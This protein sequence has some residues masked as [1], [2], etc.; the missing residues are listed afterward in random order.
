MIID[1]FQIDAHLSLHCRQPPLLRQEEL[2]LSLPSTY[3]IWSSSDL[4]VFFDRIQ[5]EP[6]QRRDVRLS[7]A[8][9]TPYRPA[10]SQLLIEDVQLA[11]LGSQYR[12]WL[13][14]EQYRNRCRFGVE[15]ADQIEA[16][17][18]LCSLQ[19]DDLAH[20]LEIPIQDQQ[21]ADFLLRAYS[22]KDKCSDS[23][24]RQAAL[25]RFHRRMLTARVLYH[26]LSLHLLADVEAL[27]EIALASSSNGLAS[28]DARGDELQTVSAQKWALSLQSRAALG[29]ALSIVKLYREATQ[30]PGWRDGPKDPIVSM[31][32]LAG[33]PVLWAWCMYAPDADMPVP[34]P[35]QLPSQLS[36]GMA[37]IG[38]ELEC[39]FAQRGGFT[40]EG[41]PVGRCSIVAC[42]GRFADAMVE[43]GPSWEKALARAAA[44]RS[45]AAAIHANR[46]LGAEGANGQWRS[47]SPPVPRRQGG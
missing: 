18:K 36:A 3:A 16:H 30:R 43:A 29:H 19:L 12:I 44:W 5:A 38:P 20:S 47:P 26:L 46:Q 28:T 37:C 32:L 2:D 6:W 42:L 17:L 14:K 45:V 10:L 31:A 40:L 25:D 4:T 39:A 34:A 9:M 27:E 41:L 15:S 7:N 13:L 24:W 11:I 22:G 33:A 1:T 8:D 21:R 35:A 23:E